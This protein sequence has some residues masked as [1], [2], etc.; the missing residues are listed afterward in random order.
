M[1]NKFN[2]DWTEDKIK[3]L[4]ICHKS[5]SHAETAIELTRKWD[6]LVTRDS[7]KNKY[8]S[9]L[10]FG[11]TKTDRA[12]IGPI[13]NRESF[14]RT[15]SDE[16]KGGQRIYVITSAVAGQKLHKTFIKSIETYCGVRNAKLIALP[17]RGA[18]SKD[19]EYDE[20]VLEQLSDSFY[21]DFTFNSNI[22][23]FDIG[24]SPSQVNPLTGIQ[25]VTKKS[26]VIVA[27]PKQSLESIPRSNTQLPY[28]LCSTGAI[29]LSNY[30][31]NRVGMIA[32]E[33]HVIGALVLEIENDKIFHIRQIQAGAEG[34]F[35][36]LDT[37]YMP[38][39]K[40]T[41]EEVS[42]FVMGDLHIGE[43]DEQV[44]TANHQI[45]NMTKP[46]YVFLHDVIN[47]KSCNHHLQH[48]I[49]ARANLPEIYRTLDNELNYCGAFLKSLSDK[50]P[51]V[52]FNIVES[53]HP[54]AV[55]RY[56]NEG[57]FVMDPPNYRASL[58]LATYVLDG[59]NPLEQYIN[60]RF[61]V[62]KNLKWLRRDEDFKINNCQCSV[63]GDLGN[64]G[65]IG[66][67]TGI[68]K[69]YGNAIIAHSHSPRQVRQTIQ[70]GTSTKLRLDYN[71]GASSWLHAGAL[72][73]RNGAKTLIIIV[74]GRWKN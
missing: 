72:L 46:K 28:L 53:N 66:N 2:G 47:A 71:R 39:G 73:Y 37:K 59:L 18:N 11:D 43:H 24:L 32:E 26:S 50:H 25:R 16:G 22:E 5:K 9:L 58:E 68:E 54:E 70:V 44:M 27:S 19:E 20:D 7:V 48:N 55:T 15:E 21:T 3:D 12:P 52:K 1:P 60:K 13:K 4:L 56:I 17:M 30:N 23:A 41:K 35:Y 40:T 14:D 74:D 10:Q 29:T 62:S 57:R 6:V 67:I 34:E 69:S 49:S 64:N 31:D 8:N 38:N 42:A 36:D 63:H 65:S 33:D 51:N 45:I 61:G